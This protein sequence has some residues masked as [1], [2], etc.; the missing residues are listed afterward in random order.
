M[1][2]TQVL[3]YLG[4]LIIGVVLGLIGG[5]GSI[6]T[7]PVLVYLLHTNPVTA[8]A[9]SLFVVGGAS[10]VGTGRNVR[11]GLIGYK[12]A[13][14]FAIP[15][16]ILVFSTRKYIVPAIP[17]YFDPWRFYPD[18]GHGDNGFLCPDYAH[19]LDFND[20]GFKNVT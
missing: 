11:K 10:L 17:D 9:Y 4:A 20:P 2:F 6:L 7:V 18:Q 3:G 13:L 5:G 19:G 1:D 15:A 12:T 16:V 14:T 8:T